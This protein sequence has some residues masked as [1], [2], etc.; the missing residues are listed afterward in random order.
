MCSLLLTDFQMFEKELSVLV[1]VKESHSVLFLG[2]EGSAVE[3]CIL[4]LLSCIGHL[5]CDVCKVLAH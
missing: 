3:D 2:G 1:I 5:C 4:L